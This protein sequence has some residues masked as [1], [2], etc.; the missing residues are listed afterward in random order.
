MN[1]SKDN[2]KNLK[3]KDGNMIGEQLMKSLEVPL[4][5]MNNINNK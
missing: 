3:D 1:N 4:Q 2:L 5:M